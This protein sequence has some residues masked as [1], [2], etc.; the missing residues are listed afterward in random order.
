VIKVTKQ[1]EKSPVPSKLREARAASGKTAAAICSEV[2][3]TRPTLYRIEKGEV[4]P[5]HTTARALYFFYQGTVPLAHIY[6]PIFSSE[7][8]RIFPTR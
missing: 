5:M 4:V 6:D 3:C 8:D 7:I 2:G 1:D